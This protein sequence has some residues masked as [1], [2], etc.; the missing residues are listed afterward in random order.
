MVVA[1]VRGEDIEWGR[2][3]TAS[4]NDITVQY[5]FECVHN[6]TN[7]VQSWGFASDYHKYREDISVVDGVL[8]FKGRPRKV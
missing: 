3:T 8:V 2:L 1:E 7:D 4:E 5:A 6:G